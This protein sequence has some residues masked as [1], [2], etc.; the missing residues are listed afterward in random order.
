MQLIYHPA[1][2]DELLRGAVSDLQTGRWLATRDLLAQTGQ[3]WALR[4]SRSQV[5]AVAA[6]PSGVVEA[7][8]REEP[9]HP[10][11]LMMRARVAV[12]R[13]LRAHRHQHDM[14]A[15]LERDAREAAQV[16]ARC[17]PK[18][19]VPWVCL[20]A[21]AQADVRQ[22][23]PEHHVKPREPMLPFGPWTLVDE[24]T[25][26]DPK[27]NREAFHRLL[28]LLREQ[29]V[30]LGAML[31][32]GQWVASWA[33]AGSPLL[34]LPLYAQAEQSRRHSAL[35][36]RADP[37]WRQYWTHEPV[38]MHALRAFEFWFRTVDPRWCSVADLSHLAYALWAGNQQVEAAHVFT[39][40]GP[41]GSTS[42]WSSLRIDDGPEGTG[43][44]LLLKARRESLGFARRAG[45][46]VPKPEP[47]PALRLG[48]PLPE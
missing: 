16:A 35:S 17:S 15:Q 20:V 33:S 27:G 32:F 22:L 2:S 31:D 44:A 41:Y 24:V 37:L 4:T 28:H 38:R 47:S 29:S 1:G 45:P 40:M 42:P 30:S 8:L 5:L 3:N 26:R 11:A 36:G 13:A 25:A 43:E 21:L 14:T 46:A 12:E 6:A 19:P 34:L 39:A 10:D 9:N 18:D 23:R 7:W 48:M